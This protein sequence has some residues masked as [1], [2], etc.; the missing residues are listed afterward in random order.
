[1]IKPQRQKC[2]A[3]NTLAA[4]THVRTHTHFLQGL[5]STCSLF[6]LV[7]T[8]W[9]LKYSFIIFLHFVYVS[10]CMSIGECV[11]TYALE[12]MEFGGQLGSCFSVSTLW[13]L[14]IGFRP[15]VKSVL[16]P[17]AFW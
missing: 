4:C 10:I 8:F 17:R 2:K 3:K 6:H 5:V 15:G 12:C 11:G 14:E 7:F 9:Y 13:V 16:S 1:M